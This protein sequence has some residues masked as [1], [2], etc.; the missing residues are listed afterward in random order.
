M[1]YSSRNYKTPD[2]LGLNIESLC[3][4]QLKND[5]ASERFIVC[6]NTMRFVELLSSMVINLER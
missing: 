4:D 6:L 2:I 1:Q 3:N 5:F